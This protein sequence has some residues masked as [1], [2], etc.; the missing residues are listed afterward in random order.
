MKKIYLLLCAS[1]VCSM[2]IAQESSTV[3]VVSQGTFL[4]TSIPLRDMPTSNEMEDFNISNANVINHGVKRGNEPV[5]AATALPQ[6]GD[7]V[8]QKEQGTR[9][10]L[11]LLQNCE[12]FSK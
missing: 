7:P 6:N 10:A 8:Q 1:L 12:T 3:Q 4:G 11:N 2:T 5:N 9:Q